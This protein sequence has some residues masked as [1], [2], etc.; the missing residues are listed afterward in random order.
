MTIRDAAEGEEGE[1]LALVSAV[2]EEFLPLLPAEA[3]G[4]LRT[5]MGAL[6][7]GTP[8]T[9][10]IVAA[11]DGRMV[12]AVWYY[13]DG[14]GYHERW[15]VGWAAFRLL[16]VAPS[17]R[18]L[19]TGRA[20]VEECVRRAEA[21]GCAAIGMHTMPFMRAAR[22]LYERMG[23]GVVP[24]LSGEHVSGFEVIGYLKE[25]EPG[26]GGAIVRSAG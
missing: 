26:A 25:L 13:R 16:A 14:S 23:F 2:Y 7:R 15:P 6:A 24:A 18:G 3:A 5:D 22:R 12:G 1:V 20:L 17:A 11:R 4:Q 8:F 19:G 9:D 21:S 10:L